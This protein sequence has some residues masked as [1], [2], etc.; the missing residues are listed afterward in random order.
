MTETPRLDAAETFIWL[1]ARLVDRHRYSALFK[2]GNADAVVTALQ[3]YQN[4]D[5]GFGHA[6]EP[7]GRGP[8]SQPLHTHSALLML[9]E[10]GRFNV[11]MVGRALDYLAA[12]TASDGGT[13]SVLPSARDYPRAPWWTVGG[14]TPHGSLM[15]T[16]AFVG[17]LYKNGVERPW[18][19]PATD[20]CWQAIS[21]VEETHPYEV[22]FCLAFLDH[23]PDH[24]RAEHEAERLGRLVRERRLVLLDPARPSEVAI[25]N[26]Y[27]PGEVHTPLDYALRPDS[28]ARCW[29]SDAEIET[30]LDALVRAQA[31]DGGWS[32]NWR[33]WNPATTIAWRGWVTLRALG[34]LRAYG[35]LG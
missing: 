34:I 21:A 16:A 12:V 25:P 6:L 15:P 28:L 14:D 24:A 31:D 8:T 33:A 26:G 32:F 1:N 3:P 19:G 17:L 29:F 10:V 22:E 27:A 23:A 18:L 20:F 9:D 4:P 30:A 2:N 13:P 35:R 11:P 5:G 7:D